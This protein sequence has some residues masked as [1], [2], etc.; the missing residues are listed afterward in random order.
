[1]VVNVGQ[2]GAQDGVL[3]EDPEVGLKEGLGAVNG[4]VVVVALRGGEGER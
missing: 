3:A 2:R 1:M 4:V